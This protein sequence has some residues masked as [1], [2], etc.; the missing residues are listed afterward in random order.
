MSDHRNSG[1]QG[2]RLS[3]Y[4]QYPE[5][6]TDEVHS[7]LP[8]A[9]HSG[10]EFIYVLSG[11]IEL[12]VANKMEILESGDGAWYQSEFVH[13]LRSLGDQRATVL[14][15]ICSCARESR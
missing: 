8:Q 12:R 14:V 13:K 6:V 4:I 1:P 15:V 7:D 11:K 3:V 10:E 5:M 2:A 9:I